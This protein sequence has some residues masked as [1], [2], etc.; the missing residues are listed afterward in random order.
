MLAGIGLA[1]F[2][3]CQ[4]PNVEIFN[5]TS[6]QLKTSVHQS[7]D[8]IL[9][10][11][12]GWTD[13]PGIREE[14]TSDGAYRDLNGRIARS[15]ELRKALGTALGEYSDALVNLK[16]AGGEGGEAAN[17]LGDSLEQLLSIAQIDLGSTISDASGQLETIGNAISGIRSTKKIAK[18]LKRSAPI[19][20]QVSSF[21]VED[22]KAAQDLVDLEFALQENALTFE[23]NQYLGIHDSA[24]FQIDQLGLALNAEMSAA[25]DPGLSDAAM[26]AAMTGKEKRIQEISRSL[27]YQLQL[28][29]TAKPM[30]V[31][32]QAKLDRIE[33][34]RDL[35]REL[36][37]RSVAASLA[38]AAAHQ[39]L[40]AEAESFADFNLENLMFAAQ[41]ITQIATQ[42]KVL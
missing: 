31:E 20:N 25:I 28:L 27:Q 24:S 26:N 9:A 21:L 5:A 3:S 33:T 34:E 39:S 7:A 37:T 22:F 8:V 15:W 41:Q 17:A 13:L 6:Q 4:S 42:L 35:K 40:T 36:L 19:V 2:T 1:F 11:V 30:M 14:L 32:Y 10:D 23:Y 29:A 12:N 16:N 38:W 18:A